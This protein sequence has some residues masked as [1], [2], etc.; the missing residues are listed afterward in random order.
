MRRFVQLII[1][2]SLAVAIPSAFAGPWGALPDAIARLQTDPQDRL[3]QEV[4]EE[5]EASILREVSNGNLAAV[6]VLMDTYASLVVQLG[7]GESRLRRQEQRTS[8][9]LLAWGDARTESTL[10]VAATAW[11]LSARFDASGPAIER[12]RRFLLPPVDPEDGQIWQS[13]VDGA[14]LVYQ[15][16]FRIRVGCSVNDRR[17]R[18]NE[19]NF[20]WVEVPGTWIDSTEVTN[21]RYRLCVD[22]GQC[23][24]PSEDTAFNDP[25]RGQHPV[26][27]L[28]WK[29]AR[30]YSR[31]VGRRLP[32]ESEWERAA[33]GKGFRARFPWGN[34]RRSELANVWDETMAAGRGSLPVSTFAATGWGVYDMS[35]NVWEW[36][37]DR[38]QFGFKELPQDG[39]PI[40]TGFGRVVR[41]GSW[42]RGID[43]ARVSARSWFEE[44]YHGDDLGFRCAL[45]R[46]SKISD[47]KVLS[48]ADSVFALRSAPGSELVGVE[49]STEDLRYLERR[50]L[51]WLMLERRAGEA[52]LQAATI[53][54]RDPRDPVALDLLEWVEG[55]MVELAVGGE[56]D[57]LISLRS[58]Y[59]KTVAGSPRFDRRVRETDALLV[60]TLNACGENGLRDANRERA[61]K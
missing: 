58:R 4:V 35:G 16:P 41:G 6:A 1:G 50:T 22:A 57:A 7:D 59:L 30:E 47:S 61:E 38:Y 10:T 2:V 23:T 54:R 60:D 49:L 12:L 42:R 11:T 8:A 18:A 19:V 28:R 15:P 37:Q 31:W 25:G 24:P 56:I 39:S 3:A 52:V 51:T 34:G 43:L 21:Q 20:R 17:C 48:L 26:V 5:A 45:D 27:G 9:A 44:S 13:P 14:N 46:S 55:E 40:R 53:L 29:Q 33:R 36:C 32:S